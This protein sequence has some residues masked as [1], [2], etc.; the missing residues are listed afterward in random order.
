MFL[1]GIISGGEFVWTCSNEASLTR[2]RRLLKH[3]NQPYTPVLPSILCYTATSGDTQSSSSPE[4]HIYPLRTTPLTKDTPLPI[5]HALEFVADA[6]VEQGKTADAA[7]IFEDL[8][9]KYDRIRLAYWQ[10]RKRECEV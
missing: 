3:L 10:H 7:E 5:S 1:L 4:D 2:R 8:G 6:L 9:N